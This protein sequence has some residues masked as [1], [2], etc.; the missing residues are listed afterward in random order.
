MWLSATAPAVHP[1]TLLRRRCAR[2]ARLARFS[3]GSFRRR[4]E[5]AR[6]CGSSDGRWIAVLGPVTFRLALVV[7]RRSARLLHQNAAAEMTTMTITKETPIIGPL[8][9]KGYAAL[10][11]PHTV[12]SCGGGARIRSIG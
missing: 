10:L 5:Y 12:K 6:Q 4:S 11:L 7:P 3:S 9:S 2:A 8:M 1:A